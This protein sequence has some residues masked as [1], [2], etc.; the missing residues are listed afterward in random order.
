MSFLFSDGFYLI[1]SLG[2]SGNYIKIMPA[3]LKPF[4]IKT[5]GC[6]FAGNIF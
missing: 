2:G 3:I 1:E 5:R 6:L 4:A